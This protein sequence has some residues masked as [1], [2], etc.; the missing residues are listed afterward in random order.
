MPMQCY[1]GDIATPLGRMIAI[2][3]ADGALLRLDFD[4]DNRRRR[5]DELIEQ[6]Q[7]DISAIAT[8]AEQLGQYFAGE[9]RAFDLPLAPIGNAFLQ[10]AWARLIQVPYGAIAT[11]GELAQ[12]LATSPRAYGRANAINPISIIIPCHRIIGATGKLT[13]YSGGLARKA[14]LLALEQGDV[15]ALQSTATMTSEAL[16]TA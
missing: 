13:G 4:D 9:R 7:P 15:A 16:I 11:Y 14:A 8:V 6:A 5:S 12:Q 3:D 1:C 2:V 10:S